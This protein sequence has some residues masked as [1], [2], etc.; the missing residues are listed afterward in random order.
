MLR[1]ELSCGQAVVPV[2]GG[3]DAAGGQLVLCMRCGLCAGGDVTGKF[4]LRG[5]CMGPCRS[6]PMALVGTFV[7]L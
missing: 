3:G 5:A 1:K 6:R 2:A 4:S 7:A